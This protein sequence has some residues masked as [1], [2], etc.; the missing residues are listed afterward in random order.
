MF[1]SCETLA[2]ELEQHFYLLQIMYIILQHLFMTYVELKFLFYRFNVHKT[3]NFILEF[4]EKRVNTI[5]KII[6]V[7]NKH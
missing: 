2:L 3:F 4:C 5:N 7:N 1:M 6:L